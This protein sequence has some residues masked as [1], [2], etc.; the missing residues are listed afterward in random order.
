MR[1]IFFLTAFLILGLPSLAL[2]WGAGVHLAV[3]STVLL[4]LGL[5]AP[6]VAEII[7]K[8]SQDFLYGIVAA[9]VTLAKGFVRSIHNCHTWAV[10]KAMHA[11]V[12]TEQGHAFCYGYQAHLASDVIAHNYFIPNKLII[13]FRHRTMRHTYWENRFESYI[14]PRVWEISRQLAKQS[15]AEHDDPVSYTHLTLPTN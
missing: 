10:A 9:D 1:R 12:T 6:Y 7:K 13:S 15:F 8:H 2:A 14:D 4:N 3:G 5:L 11:E